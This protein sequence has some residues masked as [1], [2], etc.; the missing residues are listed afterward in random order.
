MGKEQV[1]TLAHIAQDVGLLAA[2]EEDICRSQ[3]VELGT[4]RVRL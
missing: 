4:D 2:T 3:L 1:M